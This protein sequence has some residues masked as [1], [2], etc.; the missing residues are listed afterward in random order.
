MLAGRQ[1][2][3][4]GSFYWWRSYQFHSLLLHSSIH[5]CTLFDL[6]V[7]DIHCTCLW[8]DGQAELTCWHCTCC[9][10]NVAGRQWRKSGSFCWRRSTSSA[11]RWP[12][13]KSHRTLCSSSGTWQ[14][15]VTSWWTMCLWLSVD[16]HLSLCYQYVDRR[17]Q[18]ESWQTCRIIETYAHCLILMVVILLVACKLSGINII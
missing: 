4:C 17:W 1:C 12:T 11:S 14:S 2:R 3:R 18:K 16:F 8:K 13:T 5:W 6:C 7:P 9:L 10:Y 15:Y